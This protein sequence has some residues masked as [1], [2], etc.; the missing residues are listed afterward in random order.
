MCLK[1]ERRDSVVYIPLLS[2][3]VHRKST[4]AKRLLAFGIIVMMTLASFPIIARA[5]RVAASYEPV[6]EWERTF[7]GAEYDFCDSVQ[8]TSDGGYILAGETSSYGTGDYPDVYLIKTDASGILEWQKTFGGSNADPAYSVQQTSD[9]GYIVAGETSSY[10]SGDDDVY[11]IKTDASGILEWQK[12]FG[13]IDADWA[14][15][16]QQTSDGGYIIGGC[17]WSFGAGESDAWLIKTDADGRLE[18]QKTYGEYNWDGAEYCQQTSDGGYMIAGRTSSFGASDQD[19]YLVKTDDSGSL[20]WQKTFGGSGWDAFWSGQQTS[21]G[22]YILAGWW[23]W[24]P[25]C[26]FWLVKTRAPALDGEIT[27]YVVLTPEVYAGSQLEVQVTVENIGDIKAEYNVY[28]GN[29]WDSEGASAGNAYSESHQIIQ[30]DPG[31]SQTLTLE[32]TTPDTMLPGDYTGDLHLQMA[33]P[34]SGWEKH[35][36]YSNAINFAVEGKKWPI[37][38]NPNGGRIYVDGNPITVLTTYNWMAGSS[39]ELDPDSEYAPITGTKLVFTQWS[40]GSTADPR[41]TV[42]PPMGVTYTA[43][44]AIHYRL[45]ITITPLGAGSTTPTAD[46]YWHPSGTSVTVVETPNPGYIFDHW[47]LGFDNVGGEPS[48][49]IIMDAP[50]DLTTVFRVEPQVELP[51]FISSAKSYRPGETASFSVTLRNTAVSS[52][53]Y[54]MR[55]QIMSA[56]EESPG[57]RTL[58]LPAVSTTIDAGETE[59]LSVDWVIPASSEPRTCLA[60]LFVYD[61]N[62]DSNPLSSQ[63]NQRAG[64]LFMIDDPDVSYVEI[65][66]LPDR[67]I[68]HTQIQRFA[69]VEPGTFD[70]FEWVTMWKAI[71][72]GLLDP[73]DFAELLLRLPDQYNRLVN[74]ALDRPYHLTIVQAYDKI[75]VAFEAP[76]AGLLDET[77]RVVTIEYLKMMAEW[78]LDTSL[79]LLPLPPLEHFTIIPTDLLDQ[80]VPYY[81]Q[82]LLPI[83]VNT[84]MLAPINDPYGRDGI[85]DLRIGATDP[86]NGNPIT[87][88][89][90]FSGTGSISMRIIRP[91]PLTT[92]Q[93]ITQT[94]FSEISP[95]IYTSSINILSYFG[96]GFPPDIESV[97]TG[98]YLIT[99]Y[100]NKPPTETEPGFFGAGDQHSFTV[101][102]SID[103]MEVHNLGISANPQTIDLDE[104][105]SVDV[106]FDW[107]LPQTA[108]ASITI[109]LKEDMGFYGLFDKSLGTYTITEFGQFSSES[110]TF[111]VSASNLGYLTHTGIHR[112]YVVVT[113]S[114]IPFGTTSPTVIS[115]R[116]YECIITVRAAESMR[117]EARSPVNILVIDPLNRQVGYD[118]VSGQILNEILGATYSGP[119]S[120]PQIVIIPNVFS[121]DYTVEVF[122]TGTG[123]Y[124]ILI[125]SL[126]A[127]GLIIDSISWV[128]TA[129]EGEKYTRD[130]FLCDAGTFDTTPPAINVLCPED[131]IYATN[132]ID[133]N[134]TLSEPAA[135][136]GYSLDG[137]ANITIAGNTTLTGLL[138]GSHYM[139][140]HANDTAGNMGTSNTVHFTVDTTP[141]NITDV[142]QTPLE[143]NVQPEG[144]VIVNT[145]VIDVTGGVERVALNYTN[146]NGTWVIIEMT[147]LSVH[148]NVW[149]AII[150]PF[151]CGT[152]VTYIILAEDNA[153][154]TITTDEL[155][156][157]YQY[158]VIPEFLSFLVLSL[159]ILTTLLA[160]TVYRCMHARA[161]T[162]IHRFLL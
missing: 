141:P 52:Q 147:S 67:R 143:K 161:H 158:Q 90:F 117:I 130:V 31:A 46:A 37:T 119:G 142:S 36:E 125:N 10:G 107:T 20:E 88:C 138:D 82:M 137:Q 43:Q 11:L 9:G 8:Q 27:D 81:K 66:G 63:I 151:P 26:D 95:G 38:I 33:R 108:Q 115:R 41:E 32:W 80:P 150:P 71:G 134:F 129:K 149:S 40:D 102:S 106:G 160:L 154:N 68:I 105:S 91:V 72:A 59:S 23:S 94:W 50:Y 86:R 110:H 19:G 122:C 162:H 153:G 29:I 120:Q 34:G 35:R 128:G 6:T 39:H 15:S 152:N 100:F 104:S 64:P 148:Q 145:T 118:G 45:S 126:S 7:G 131:A 4:R 96:Q 54:W 55:I 14:N 42:V 58:P 121:G 47:R 78:A 30:L 17:T 113:L 103:G 25:V 3:D 28:I 136:V 140:V 79:G 114:W 132:S 124:E 61:S 97:H 127:E 157:E 135:W 49:T 111:A 146:G 74:L 70:Y 75:G 57:W 76:P 21:D 98:I 112:I 53:T 77:M 99:F 89:G 101:D 139:V 155:G 56:K 22:G 69:Y 109:E 48:Y 144:E 13:G 18:W 44:W 93:P 159:L 62:P 73:I 123:A 85:V 60:L 116:S 1:G 2:I 24:Y 83:K 65:L 12:T 87:G 92:T 156:Y 133:L 84:E 16:V 51:E 5:K